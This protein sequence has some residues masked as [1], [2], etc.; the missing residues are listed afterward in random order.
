MS[1]DF[2]KNDQT[3]EKF[4]QKGDAR[5]THF[6]ADAVL[7]RGN[8]W[9]RYR[10]ALSEG[11]GTATIC[12][13]FPGVE[14]AVLELRAPCFVPSAHRRGD[15]LEINHCLEGRAEFRMGDG[16]L[17]YI[18]EN[19]LF[20]STPHNHSDS[21]DLPLG[22]YG[23]IAVMIDLARAAELERCLSDV[24]FRMGALLGRIFATDDCFLIAS[25]EEVSRIF[26]G[27]YSVP[28]EARGI[29]FR[30]KVLE[31]LLYLHCF[32]PDQERQ[33]PAYARQQVEI[34]KQVQKRMTA[35]PGRR[36]TIEELA[37]Q[38]C[39]GATALKAGFK[40]VYGTSVAAYMRDYRIRL[41]ASLLRTTSK[42]VEEIASEVGYESQSKFSAAFKA[43]M[44]L[45][46][47]EYRMK[48]Q[49]RE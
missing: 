48:Y 22:L 46:P 5:P 17:Q 49:R 47:L 13:A 44:K 23:G 2:E 20:L 24:S 41:A 34:I 3:G 19:D 40:A 21:I 36:Y 31:L 42:S 28:A 29:Y 1:M 16:C 45:N 12:P 43:R 15:V 32:D 9:T 18:G 7:E 8:G 10:L 11:E 14:V 27:M 37:A 39:I 6:G 38:H 35:E 26:G 4:A 25:K 33:K 30:L